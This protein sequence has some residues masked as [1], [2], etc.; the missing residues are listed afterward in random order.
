MNMDWGGGGDSG[1]AEGVLTVGSAERGEERE[2]LCWK[3]A[4]AVGCFQYSV[5]PPTV[6]TGKGA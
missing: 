3:R 6:S 2:R 1:Q 4:E 5:N